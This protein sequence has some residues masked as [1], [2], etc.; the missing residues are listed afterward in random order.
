MHY[1]WNRPPQEGGELCKESILSYQNFRLLADMKM[2]K[3]Q[4]GEA[5]EELE[6]LRRK[7]R[8][9]ETIVSVIQRAWS[10]VDCLC[11][12]AK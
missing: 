9:M 1:C 10:Q 7:S 4:L 11:L 12:W 2:K 8:D 3:R 6:T 5:Q